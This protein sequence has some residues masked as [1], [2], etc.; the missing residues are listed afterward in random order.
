MSLTT[1][2]PVHERPVHERPVY[3]RA[4]LEPVAG[5]GPVPPTDDVCWLLSLRS[6]PVRVATRVHGTQEQAEDG[7]STAEYA[8]GT[9]AA[10]G[11]AGVLYKVITSSAL[12][13]LMRGIIAK[14]L[15][16]SF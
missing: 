9:V 4:A 10:A 3:E 7:M 2:P 15:K 11:F 12:L 1:L 5:D 8:V 13:E 6:L 16:V 14:A